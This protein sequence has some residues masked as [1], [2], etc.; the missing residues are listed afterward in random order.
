MSTTNSSARSPSEGS[1]HT[2]PDNAKD[3]VDNGLKIDTNPQDLED[4]YNYEPG[5][6]HPVHLGDIIHQKYKVLHKLGS[7][8]SANVWRCRDTAASSGGPQ[9]VAMKIAMADASTPDCPEFLLGRLIEEKLGGGPSAELFG[10]A[11]DRFEIE[12][13]NGVHCVLVHAVLGPRISDL[14]KT[15]SGD[16]GVPWREIC[17]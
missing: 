13:P 12:G 1:D 2:I 6:H 9:Y 17:F 14:P 4:I 8:G 10:L 5:G 16:P 15:K 7:G 3:W 11:L